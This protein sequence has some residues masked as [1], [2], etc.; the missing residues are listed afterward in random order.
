MTRKNEVL[1]KAA[2]GAALTDMELINTNGGFVAKML[3]SLVGGL[4][5]IGSDRDTVRKATDLL[6]QIQQ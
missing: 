5:T 1:F 3:R 2:Q 4:K 6:D